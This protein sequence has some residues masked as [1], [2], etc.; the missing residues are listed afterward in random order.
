MNG[1]IIILVTIHRTFNC[2]SWFSRLSTVDEICC[3]ESSSAST[4]SSQ[5]MME[6]IYNTKFIQCIKNELG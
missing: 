6:S 3:S 2:D 1:N 4:A 5:S